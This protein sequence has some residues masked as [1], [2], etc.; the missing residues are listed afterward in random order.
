LIGVVD[1]ARDR[2]Q[3]SMSGATSLCRRCRGW[4]AGAQIIADWSQQRP[5]W[6]HTKARLISPADLRRV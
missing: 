4:A 1:C 3:S 5:M 6:I 2:K